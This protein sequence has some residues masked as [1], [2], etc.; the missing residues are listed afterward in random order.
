MR[1]PFVL[2]G[3]SLGMR[4]ANYI[5]AARCYS[6]GMKY[7]SMLFAGLLGAQCAVAG[8]YVE[9]VDRDVR[10]GNSE[11]SQKM[12][13]QGGVGRF[14]DAEGRATL[15]KAD[16]LYIIDDADKSYIVFD[17]A[18][19]EALAR[20]LNNA[21]TQMKEQL[22]KLP[23]EQRA[24]M[25]RRMSEQMPGLLGGEQK[26]TVEAIDTGKSDK[27]GPHAC[28][29]WELKRNG[30]LDEQLCVTPYSSLPGKENFQAMFQRFA[31]VFE[32]MAKSVPMLAGMMSTEF[33]AQS[34]VNGF[35]MRIRG[36]ENGRLEDNEHLVT[37]WREEAIPA[38][39]LE[40]P[41]GYT[42][43]KMPMK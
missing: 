34:K 41:A 38:A 14:V 7:L 42:Q 32:D 30:K 6:R 33:S 28:R 39:L 21:M 8:V 26:F 10:T 40:I 25:E 15:I 20:Q 37:V 23:P 22:A 24:Q 29:V 5:A 13:V 2:H 17:K 3:A 9:M 16:T 1:I 18:T 35:P 4:R 27:V 19:M 31:V 11:L 43:K 12:Y 36:Y